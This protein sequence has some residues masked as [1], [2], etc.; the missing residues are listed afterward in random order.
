MVKMRMTEQQLHRVKRMALR[1]EAARE[2]P[3]PA[4]AAVA[5]A[6]TSCSVQ[7]G[8]IA[9]EAVG[10]EVFDR[11][12][13]EVD[14]SLNTQLECAALLRENE[15]RV[16]H[17]AAIFLAVQ[18]RARTALIAPFNVAV[19]NTTLNAVLE[20]YAGK[21]ARTVLRGP[22][23]REGTWLPS[24]VWSASNLKVH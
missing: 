2:R 7:A 20:L 1:Y 17:E 9:L 12:A 18:R 4:V 15:P 14:A 5:S 21:L 16:R 24:L 11:L 6:E 23:F 19:V 3:A 8:D 22:R 13:I 10:R